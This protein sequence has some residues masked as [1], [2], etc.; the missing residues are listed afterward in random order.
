MALLGRSCRI[1]AQRLRLSGE[2]GK[3]AFEE[4]CLGTRTRRDTPN[5]TVDI[6]VMS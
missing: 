6:F 2:G 5:R 3:V 4:F 1:C